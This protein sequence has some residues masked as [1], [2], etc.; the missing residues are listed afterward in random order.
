MHSAA[1][2]ALAVPALSEA[3]AQPRQ[4]EADE[5]GAGEGQGHAAGEEDHHEEQG[6]AHG[7][8]APRRGQ[9]V[10]QA[11]EGPAQ[12]VDEVGQLEGLAHE[13]QQVVR[14]NALAQV[15]VMKTSAIGSEPKRWFGPPTTKAIMSAS[16]QICL[17]P[18]GGFSRCRCS[19]IQSWKLNALSFVIVDRPSPGPLRVGQFISDDVR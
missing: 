9:A 12:E 19:S 15:A 5:G 4:L 10:H 18:T 11:R 6:R 1:G 7:R 14:R 8:S 3:C 17:L 16:S 2:L 13:R